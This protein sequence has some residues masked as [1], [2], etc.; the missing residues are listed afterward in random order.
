MNVPVNQLGKY[1]GSFPLIVEISAKINNEIIHQEITVEE[2]EIIP[3]DSILKTAWTGFDIMQLETESQSS[4]IINEIIFESV[5]NRILSLYTAFLC[6]EDTIPV[7]ED[8]G[9]NGEGPITTS[10]ELEKLTIKAYPNPFINHLEFTLEKS[11]QLEKI[12]IYNVSG[13]KIKEISVEE[14]C[15]TYSWDGKDEQEGVVKP[16]I[17]LVVARYGHK[18]LTLKIQKV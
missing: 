5:D 8:C 10:S 11:D 15:S 13:Q 18:I 6:L 17:Y 14:G 7:C 3:V 1:N 4:Q 2:R 16:G 9:E 12:E